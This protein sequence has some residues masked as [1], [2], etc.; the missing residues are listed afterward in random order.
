MSA[1]RAVPERGSS[2]GSIDQVQAAG[3]KDCDRRHLERGHCLRPD[4]NKSGMASR[5]I[6]L[7][8]QSSKMRK[9][10]KGESELKNTPISLFL[11]LKRIQNNQRL[12]TRGFYTSKAAGFK[13][14]DRR[15]LERG[16][17]LRPGDN[18]SRTSAAG[19]GSP[20]LRSRR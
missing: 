1:T 2:H 10:K 9:D 15:H 11:H 6:F 20:R 12:T 5:K 19:L 3:F 16:H 7:G 4:D 8:P 14:C 18:K 17:C 13:D